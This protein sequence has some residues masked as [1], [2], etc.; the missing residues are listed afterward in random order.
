MA[1]LHPTCSSSSVLVCCHLLLLLLTSY[2]SAT[3]AAPPSTTAARLGVV[4]AG[5]GRAS[6]QSTD[7]I[8]A[9]AL[10]AG[11][12]ALNELPSVQEIARQ[13]PEL[14]VLAALLEE[15]GATFYLEQ[16]RQLTMFMP[17]NTAFREFAKQLR[18]KEEDNSTDEKEERREG[19]RPV[20]DLSALPW[21]LKW[22]VLQYHIVPNEV[23]D[24]QQ[25]TGIPQRSDAAV[26]NQFTL[27]TWEG[28]PLHFTK[29][30]YSFEDGSS[31]D[32]FDVEAARVM[33][34]PPLFSESSNGIVYKIDQVLLPPS[35][36]ELQPFL[37]TAAMADAGETTTAEEVDDVGAQVDDVGVERGVTLEEEEEKEE[38][39]LAAA[40]GSGGSASLTPPEFLVE[41]NLVHSQWQQTPSERRHSLGLSSADAPQPPPVHTP[42]VTNGLLSSPV[43]TV[44]LADADIAE[45]VAERIQQQEDNQ[46]VNTGGGGAVVSS[47]TAL[48]NAGDLVV[49]QPPTTRPSTGRRQTRRNNNNNDNDNNDSGNI[50]AL[51]RVGSAVAITSSHPSNFGWAPNNVGWKFPVSDGPTFPLRA[52]AVDKPQPVVATA[53]TD[54][55]T[56][57]TDDTTATT[58]DTTTLVVPA[59]SSPSGSLQW[60][61]VGSVAA[62]AAAEAAEAIAA[63]PFPFEQVEQLAPIHTLGVA[64]GL[65]PSYSFAVGSGGEGGGS[66]RSPT[67]LSFLDGSLSGYVG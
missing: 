3:S 50:Q 59:G 67:P 26:D 22:R 27:T 32:V 36:V 7:G 20:G 43:T 56:A 24:L 28:Q 60:P 42:D 33:G 62:A 41:T 9:D 13:D 47:T 64:P 31:S 34:S 11:P 1:R 12:V 38:V 6:R 39:S 35:F 15:I 49:P 23:V 29:Q 51:G 66:L 54:D 45:E 14:S 65:L 8:Q 37:T 57:T 52:F 10:S 16:T 40:A 19:G 63:V 18:P 5:R 46:E 58:D 53:T 17:T 4:A 2:P 55:T 61:V 25:A 21:E 30:S 48:L 44:T